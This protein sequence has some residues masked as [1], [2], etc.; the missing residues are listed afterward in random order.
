MLDSMA[1]RAAR[2]LAKLFDL[3]AALEAGLLPAPS[4]RREVDPIP[5]RKLAS[6]PR[7]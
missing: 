7:S 6:G 2:R 3:D 4:L 5:L 1:E